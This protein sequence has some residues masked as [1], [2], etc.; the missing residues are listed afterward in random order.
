MRLKKLPLLAALLILSNSTLADCAGKA[1]EKVYIDSIFIRGAG[2]IYVG[3]SGNEK[4]LNCTAASNIYLALDTAEPNA[5]EMY[6][7]IRSAQMQ[8]RKIYL[9]IVDNSRNCKI[10][11]IVFER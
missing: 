11:H 9:R 5:N 4:L 10:Q 6:G 1:C 2:N 3:T 8:N 7:L